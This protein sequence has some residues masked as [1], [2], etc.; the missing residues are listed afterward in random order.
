MK[1][2]VTVLI[3]CI[4]CQT[5]IAHA[6]NIKASSKAR[7][8]K[9]KPTVYIEFERMGDR[10]PLR[11]GESNTGIWLRLHNNTKWSIIL[12]MQD[13]PSKDYGD[14]SLFYDE[15]SGQKITF[16]RSCHV[17][18]FNA[19]GSGRSLLFSIPAEHLSEGLGIRIQFSYGWEDLN[20]V[21]AGQ[22][23]QHY[24]LFYSAQLPTDVRKQGK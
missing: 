21:F 16:E 12:N 15:L 20:K 24:V 8:K 18:S 11:V 14:A 10:K 1:T 5:A 23:P 7:L 9:D 4:L 22:E 2:V 17:C 3:A 13:V 19:L 6:Q